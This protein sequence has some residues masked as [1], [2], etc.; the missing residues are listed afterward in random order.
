ML[1]TYVHALGAPI[2]PLDLEI[3]LPVDIWMTYHPG[4]ARIPRVRRLI[5]WLITAFSPR[6]FP[7]FRDK[8]IPPPELKQHCKREV[9]VNPF[10]GFAG[11][12]RRVG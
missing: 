6:T 11:A 9:L 12:S 7:W 2:V 1:P 10:A 4:A 3:Y 8:F 5:D